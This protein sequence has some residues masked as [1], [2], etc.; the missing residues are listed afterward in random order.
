MVNQVW[1]AAS[2]VT[3]AMIAVAV[4]V[5][6]VLV[7][8]AVAGKQVNEQRYNIHRRLEATCRNGHRGRGGSNGHR[9]RGFGLR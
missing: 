7:T 3:V 2:P 1:E 4:F 5:A 8:V 6:T 9:D